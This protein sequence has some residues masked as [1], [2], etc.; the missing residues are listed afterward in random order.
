MANR[1]ADTLSAG[2]LVAPTRS[3]KLLVVWL[4]ACAGF[5]YEVRPCKKCGII[6]E[7]SNSGDPDPCLGNLPGVS[8][9]CCGHGVPEDAYINFTN[10]VMIRGFTREES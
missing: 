8:N 2:T 6:F 5:G 4:P 3:H 9:A 7:G 10:G 1:N